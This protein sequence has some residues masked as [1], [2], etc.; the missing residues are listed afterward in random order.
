[1][2]QAADFFVSYTTADRA[3]AEWIAWQLEVDGYKVVFQGW[4]FTPGH[5]W[6]HRMQQAT[7]RSQVRWPRRPEWSFNG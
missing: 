4:D 5:D 6:A 2:G 3:W 7:M 1:M